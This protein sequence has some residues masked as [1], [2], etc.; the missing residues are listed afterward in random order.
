MRVRWVR[1]N[2]PVGVIPFIIWE[3]ELP[4]GQRILAFLPH[5]DDGRFIGASLSLLNRNE[6]GQPRNRVRIVVVCPG[7]R[8]VEGD[9]TM[10]AKSQLRAEEAVAWAR[11]LG[12]EP[13]QLT[14]F[15]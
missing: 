10:E 11:E 6:D 5:A 4:R 12:Y 14:Q 3:E 1:R 8:S 7:Y 15:R 9:L 2:R 13:G